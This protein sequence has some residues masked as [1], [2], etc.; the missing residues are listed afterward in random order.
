MY[1]LGCIH[2]EQISGALIDSKVVVDDIAFLILEFLICPE[3]ECLYTSID[4]DS[5]FCW[6]FRYAFCDIII[7]TD[8]EDN[9]D[10]LELIEL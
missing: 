8:I 3:C 2:A 7:L 9:E 1:T 5:C 4:A 6:F 10:N